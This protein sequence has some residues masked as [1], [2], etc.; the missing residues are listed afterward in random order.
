[1]GTC[2]SC[3]KKPKTRSIASFPRLSSE[4]SD[5]IGTNLIIEKKT[6]CDVNENNYKND[7]LLR[8]LTNK[9][10][11]TT[12]PDFFYKLNTN[13]FDYYDMISEL[14][15]NDFGT[16]FL[17]KIMNSNIKRI[18]REIS[19][20]DQKTYFKN[21]KKNVEIIRNLNYPK[22]IKL[23][24]VYRMK[25]YHYEIYEY[26]AHGNLENFFDKRKSLKEKQIADL[27]YQ[28]LLAVTYAHQNNVMD[29]NINLSNILIRNIDCADNLD[30]VCKFGTI[31]SLEKEHLKDQNLEKYLNFIAPEIIEN[32]SVD[33]S[34]DMWSI[35]ILTYKLLEGKYPFKLNKMTVKLDDRYDLTTKK[36]KETT[37]FAKD[38]I[39]KLLEKN[40]KCRLNAFDALNHKWFTNFGLKEKYTVIEKSK[41]ERFMCNMLSFGLDF[42]LKQLFISLIVNSLPNDED[43]KLLEK[44]FTSIDPNN[45]GKISREEL[46]KGFE[47]IFKTDKDAHLDKVEEIF[48]NIDLNKNDN[49]DYDEFISACVDKNVLLQEKYLKN[50]FK[51]LDVKEIGLITCNDITSVLCNIA[52]N[53]VSKESLDNFMNEINFKENVLINFASFRLLM[54]RILL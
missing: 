5:K 27:I 8:T 26:C 44:A 51:S 7:Y 35:G 17:V 2:E 18:M 46:I 39:K 31:Y 9:E 42:K 14:K 45:D 41:M 4:Y 23:Y 47:I 33:K 21:I 10:E 22:I 38:F 43:I 20:K 19:R 36:L 13:P 50:A 52:K 25:G 15:S 54:E 24:Q 32:S 6:S 1:M 30:V 40:S 29:L 16:I 3:E 34:S 53:P 49:I 28:V 48:K 11:T 12:S 37:S